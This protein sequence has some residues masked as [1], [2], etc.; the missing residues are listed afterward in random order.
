[1]IPILSAAIGSAFWAGI[2]ASAGAI[3]G[4]YVADA[5]IARLERAE[6]PTKSERLDESSGKARRRV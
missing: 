6:P 4:M 2:L 1:M 5:L 3:A